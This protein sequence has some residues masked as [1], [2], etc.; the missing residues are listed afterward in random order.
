[1]YVGV[2]KN[3]LRELYCSPKYEMNVILSGW[4]NS[5]ELEKS[6]VLLQN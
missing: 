1:M 2:V 4:L 5:A 6:N 3:I